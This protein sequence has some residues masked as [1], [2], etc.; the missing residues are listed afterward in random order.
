MT[1]ASLIGCGGH[2]QILS[3]A[4]LTFALLFILSFAI[5]PLSAQSSGSTAGSIIGTVKDGGSNLIAGA[6][7]TAKQTE[8]N[9]TRTVTTNSD[10]SYLLV[11]LPPGNYQLTVQQEGFATRTTTLEL[12]LGNTA[13]LDVTLSVG[14]SSE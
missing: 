5:I 7:I 8:T 1:I 9:F 12:T 2:M 3:A 6:S 4:R 10:G 14:T 11:Q 13:L